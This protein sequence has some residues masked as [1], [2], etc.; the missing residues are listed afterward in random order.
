MLIHDIRVIC[1]SERAQHVR[2]T[3]VRHRVFTG[4]AVRGQELSLL[5]VHVLQVRPD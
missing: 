5:Q 2:A 1:R 4:A 3:S